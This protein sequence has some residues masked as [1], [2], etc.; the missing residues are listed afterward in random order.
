M[1][2]IRW[3]ADLANLWPSVRNANEVTA[4]AHAIALGE[5]AHL[6]NLQM[7]DEARSTM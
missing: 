6:V 5:I 2:L 4:H 7:G 1:Q 3:A